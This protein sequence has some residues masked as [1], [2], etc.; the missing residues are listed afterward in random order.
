MYYN[1]NKNIIM[2]ALSRAVL[3]S[4]YT[5]DL[6]GRH[7]SPGRQDFENRAFEN[8]DDACNI[9]NIHTQWCF[10]FLWWLL[11]SVRYAAKPLFSFPHHNGFPYPS[12]LS[13][14]GAR[15]SSL[16][17]L[18]IFLLNTISSW[19]FALIQLMLIGYG[20]SGELLFSLL[21]CHLFC[22]G[23]TAKLRWTVLLWPL[24]HLLLTSTLGGVT[25]NPM[26]R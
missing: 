16:G 12:H 1:A 7:Q 8:G 20:F 9:F 11:S 3:S 10:A 18:C 2:I 21:H 22:F 24:H 13:T 5:D 25:I 4:T 23:W 15:E 6:I 19:A 14:G 17:L 26:S